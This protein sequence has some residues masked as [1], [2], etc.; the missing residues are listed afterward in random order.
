MNLP[1]K[2]TVLRVIMVPFF[3]A[4]LLYPLAG[5]ASKYVALALFCIASLTDFLDG[6]LARSRNLITDFGKFLDP[7][8]DKILVISTMIASFVSLDLA[9]SV[10]QLLFY[11]TAFLSYINV[12]KFLNTKSKVSGIILISLSI[13]SISFI[14]KLFSNNTDIYQNLSREMRHESL[15]LYYWLFF[16]KF[17]PACRC[18]FIFNMHN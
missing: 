6:Y 10:R 4:F 14:V 3:V 12:V 7:L 15:Y 9:N 1:N 18:I 5:D 8:A 17:L 2:L 16:Y 11:M 13:S